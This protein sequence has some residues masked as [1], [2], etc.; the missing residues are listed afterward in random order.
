LA[1]D[2]FAVVFF[3]WEYPNPAMAKQQMNKKDFFTSM[4]MC[5]IYNF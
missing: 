2:G 1:P 3:G 4:F 5:F